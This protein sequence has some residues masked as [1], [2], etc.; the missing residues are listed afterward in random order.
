[1]V[2]AGALMKT[3]RFVMKYFSMG[4]KQDEGYFVL[5]EC[6]SG[7]SQCLECPGAAPKVHY[8]KMRSS[9]WTR[10]WHA[11]NVSSTS[12][13]MSKDLPTQQVASLPQWSVLDLA[14]GSHAVDSFVNRLQKWRDSDQSNCLSQAKRSLTRNTQSASVPKLPCS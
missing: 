4:S 7:W 9:T 10:T 5:T 6:D 14:T 2:D 12:F 8:T 1:M 11:G 13:M 3:F